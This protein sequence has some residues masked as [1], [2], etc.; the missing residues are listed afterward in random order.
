MQHLLQSLELSK[1]VKLVWTIAGK[2]KLSQELSE[3]MLD[4]EL[5]HIIMTAHAVDPNPPIYLSNSLILPISS[6]STFQETTSMTFAR[7][8]GN[9]AIKN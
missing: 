5:D 1:Y 3:K 8:S 9:D 2:N 7:V 4:T 6:S